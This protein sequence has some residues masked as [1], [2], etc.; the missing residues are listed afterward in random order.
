M[1]LNHNTILIYTLFL[2]SLSDRQSKEGFEEET[3]N[4]LRD[5]E[6][7]QAA[8]ALWKSLDHA[9]EVEEVVRNLPVRN[10]IIW[11]TIDNMKTR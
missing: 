4:V 7:L 8:E 11:L 9:P 10:P 1:K 3:Q 5:Q 6:L 2:L